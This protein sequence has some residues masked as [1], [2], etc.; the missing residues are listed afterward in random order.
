MNQVIIEV[1]A[2]VA[3]VSSCPPDVDVEIVDYDNQDDL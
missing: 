3:T 1:L 2:G